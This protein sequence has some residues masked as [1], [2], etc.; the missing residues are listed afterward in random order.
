MDS[1]PGEPGSFPDETVLLWQKFR[2]LTADE[3][4]AG[5]FLAVRVRLVCVC[6]LPCS[7]RVPI[8]VCHRLLGTGVFGFLRV[9]G[10]AVHILFAAGLAFASCSVDLENSVFRPINVGVYAETE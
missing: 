9:E 8:V 4:I 5:W 3:F 10:V 6:Y 2:H 1:M 7:A